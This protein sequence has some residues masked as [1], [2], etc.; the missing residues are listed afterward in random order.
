[1]RGDAIGRTL[2]AWAGIARNTAFMP[3]IAMQVEQRA[4]IS[5]YAAPIIKEENE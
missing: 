3:G 4:I 1:M 2:L 5:L